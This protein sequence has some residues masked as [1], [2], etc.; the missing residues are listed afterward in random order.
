LVTCRLFAREATCG[1][2]EFIVLG[3]RGS[4]HHATIR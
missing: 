4:L 3:F 1:C 2:A